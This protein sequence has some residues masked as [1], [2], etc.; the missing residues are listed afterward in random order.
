MADSSRW[1]G[2][3][4]GGGVRDKSFGSGGHSGLL[5]A[6][7]ADTLF[8]GDGSRAVLGLCDFFGAGTS[9]VGHGSRRIIGENA[10]GMVGG[11]ILGGA[12][13]WI[14]FGRSRIFRLGS[15]FALLG[16]AGLGLAVFL[17]RRSRAGGDDERAGFGFAGLLDENAASAGGGSENGEEGIMLQPRRQANLSKRMTA[18]MIV[19]GIAALILLQR[20]FV[21]QVV[22]GQKHAQTLIQ[23]TTIPI[24]LSPP[25]GLVL[26][27]NGLPLAENRARYDV[28]LYV[29]ELM[30]NYA[31]AHRG[32]LPMT[33]VEVGL[34]EKKRR[35]KQVDIVKI[36]N[37]TA[38]EPLR[39]LGIVPNYEIDE[40]RKHSQQRPN[41]PFQ[42]ATQIDFTTLSRM[43]ERDPR[44]PGVQEA[45]RPVRWYPYGALASHV[46]GF[47][48]AP[49]EQTLETFQ[50][51]VIGKEGIEKG[52]E[53]DLEGVPGGKILKKNNLGFIMEEQGYQAPVPG[54]NVYLTLDVRVQTIVEGVMRR[55]GRGACVVMD[56]NSGDILAMCSV[57]NFDP[58]SFV[59]GG[60]GKS[61]DWK[62]LMTAESKPMLNRAL[63]AYAPG[64]T[65]KTLTALAALENPAA[66]FTPQ[67]VI[68]S[69]GAIEMAG[70]TWH[71][72]NPDGQGSI[73]LKRGLA[74]S[75]NTFFYQLGVRTGIESMS[76][77]GK[78][79]GFGQKLL[80]RPDGAPALAGE[81]PGT[82][83]GR[84]WM[85]NRMAQR[86]KSYKTKIDAWV[87]EGQKSPRPKPPAVERWSDGHTANTSIGQGYVRVTPLQMA[88]MLSAVANGGTV[89]QPRLV[90]GVGRTT[91]K[92][93][94]ATKEYPV[95]VKRGDL[96]V[97]PENLAAVRE[98]LR[99][100]VTEGTGK[101]AA[102]KDVE[103]AGKTGSAQFVTKIGGSTVK[104]TRTWFTGFAPLKE[105]KY[106]VIVLVEG[107]VSGG[108]TCAPLAGEVLFKLFEMEKG[109][110]PALVYQAPVVGHFHGVTASDGSYTPGGGSPG[111]DDNGGLDGFFNW[112]DEGFGG[113]ASRGLRRR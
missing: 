50:P 16:G 64:S 21:V 9:R 82:M 45:A 92:G 49:E 90:Q 61:T 112:L 89:Y 39:N 96:Q 65:F 10:K 25:R 94:K 63:G 87:A 38:T 81:D 14:N 111:D 86:K 19:V 1:A 33:L 95:A 91:E 78:R 68:H 101:N 41:T 5:G 48:G 28:D 54:H 47:V 29:R 74:M 71:D 66:K 53:Q 60:T 79:I 12:N 108:S 15:L 22:E 52:F 88:V 84:E 80:L 100:V 98:G 113:G 6:F 13:R 110:P 67:T 30:G 70:R 72:W 43:A 24:L 73:A 62:Q 26:D 2:L 104:D 46:M 20:L 97:K 23:Q 56:P 58:N 77:M 4:W 109:V 107:G 40:L 75:C 7:R 106:V 35:Q 34:G 17:E 32:R 105:P 3:V 42:L 18:T 76:E 11:G 37:E 103:V 8:L 27:R 99:A 51:E 55:V 44:I 36:V 69:P 85:E 59:P 57:P 93:T 31:R 102:V 83:P